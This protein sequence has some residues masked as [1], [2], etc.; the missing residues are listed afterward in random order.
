MYEGGNLTV[1]PITDAVKRITSLQCQLNPHG[2]NELLNMLC[3]WWVGTGTDV[4]KA[5]IKV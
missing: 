5:V 3:E 4:V 2:Q 1:T